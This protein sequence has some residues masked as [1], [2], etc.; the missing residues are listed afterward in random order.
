MR[1]ATCAGAKKK[2]TRGPGR[3]LPLPRWST[4]VAPI[5]H[6]HFKRASL[7]VGEPIGRVNRPF[8]AA[9]GCSTRLLRHFR[10]GADASVAARRQAGGGRHEPAR[11]RTRV[12]SDGDGDGG[13]YQLRRW[14]N[15]KAGAHWSSGSAAGSCSAS[16]AA[17]CGA[18]GGCDARWRGRLTEVAED[19]A[20]GRAVGDE[21]DDPHRAATAGAHQRKAVPGIPSAIPPLRSRSGRISSG[22]D[23]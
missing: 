14:S 10:A 1:L 15:S 18:A 11:R 5:T 23:P 19:V 13:G 17:H 21:G 9:T 3:P 20:H 22:S 4:W 7:S 12:S 2:A 6:S 16:A 8:A